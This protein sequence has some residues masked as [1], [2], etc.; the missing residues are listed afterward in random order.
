M[1]IERN[2]FGGST[3]ASEPDNLQRLEQIWKTLRDFDEEISFDDKRIQD[4]CNRVVR[5]LVIIS[6]PTEASKIKEFQHHLNAVGQVLER[7]IR[8]SSN[9]EQIFISCLQTLYCLLVSN[10]K[11]SVAFSSVLCCGIDHPI[12]VSL[13]FTDTPS[14]GSGIIFDIYDQ[15]SIPKAIK[16]LIKNTGNM[17][18]DNDNDFKKVTQ[19]LCTWLRTFSGLKNLSHCIIYFLDGLRVCLSFSICFN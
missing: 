8:Q 7:I 6:V 18:V 4:E 2:N 1:A 17:G 9:P 10:G 5:E 11:P 14:A 12:F 15:D 3:Q 13:H 16:L 19:T